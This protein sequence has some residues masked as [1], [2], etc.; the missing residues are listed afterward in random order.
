[1]RLSG[2][3]EWPQLLLLT[4]MFGAAFAAWGSSPDRIPVHWGMSGAPD[5]WGGRFEG[6]LL[7]PLLA[8]GLYLL[9]AFLPR[10]DPARVSYAAFAGAYAVV[11]MAVLALLAALEALVLLWIHGQRMNV[12][13]AVP[14]LLGLMF[15]VIGIVLPGLEPN[16]FVGIRTPWTLSS[17]RSWV[18]SHRVGRQ[19]M[20]AAGVLMLAAGAIGRPW[21]MLAALA[22]LMIGM[23]ATVAFSYRVWRDDPDKLPPLGRPPS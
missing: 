3:G 1:M 6:L 5:R 2:R 23:I 8:L 11:R 21:A 10:F 9:L 17:R 22:L 18:A 4:A 12:G 13:V 15:I 16:W 20:I 19:V 7:L 14:V